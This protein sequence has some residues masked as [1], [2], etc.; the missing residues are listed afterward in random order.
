MVHD[1]YVAGVGSVFAG[2]DVVRGKIADDVPTDWLDLANIAGELLLGIQTI[3]SDYGLPPCA[4]GSRPGSVAIDSW[5]ALPNLGARR[6]RA[7]N[8]TTASVFIFNMNEKV[9]FRWD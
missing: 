5:Q 2:R 3:Q 1:L 8:V 9:T 6:I 7:K 4:Y